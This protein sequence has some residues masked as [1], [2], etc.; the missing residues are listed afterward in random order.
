MTMKKLLLPLVTILVLGACSDSSPISDETRLDEASFEILASSA[1]EAN[2]QQGTPLPSLD[3]LLRRTYKAIREQDGHAQGIRLL[4]AGHTLRGIIAVLGP[5]VVEEAMAGVDQ[6]ISRLEDRFAGKVLPDGMQRAYD[7]AKALAER[8]H[9]A[10]AA[11]NYPGALGAALASAD[12]IRS[13]SVKYRARKA[14]ERAGKWF[15]AAKAA[16]GGSPTEDE[17]TALKKAR[18]FRNAA[19]KAYKEKKYR[20]A[21][22]FGLKSIALSKEVYKGR[23]GG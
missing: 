19:V 15:Q 22:D 11:E 18:R 2:D 23:S 6:A 17:V 20:K 8:G 12:L 7:R 4:K 16:V 1:L 10:L 5:E 14:I 3:N 21:W 13:L 9:E